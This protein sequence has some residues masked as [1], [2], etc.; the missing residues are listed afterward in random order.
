MASKAALAKEQTRKKRDFYVRLQK[1]ILDVATEE[2][3]AL[4]SKTDV[5][6]TY[7]SGN[8]YISF[9]QYGKKLSILLYTR[10]QVVLQ[11]SEFC[12][13]DYEKQLFEMTDDEVAQEQFLEYM[14]KILPW[15]IKEF[16]DQGRIGFH[17]YMDFVSSVGDFET[18]Y[19]KMI[20]IY[21]LS[22]EEED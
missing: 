21:P 4:L 5:K 9:S 13:S 10:G 7:K 15:L 8:R 6:I 22:D 1:T 18:A 17:G 20:E 16:L 11:L 12:H 2:M 19:E 3:M 14:A